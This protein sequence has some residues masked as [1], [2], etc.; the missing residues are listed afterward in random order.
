[1]STI[2]MET[3]LTLAGRLDTVQRLINED[4]ASTLLRDEL[5]ALRDDVVRYET[6]R[7]GLHREMA[8]REAEAHRLSEVVTQTRRRNADVASLYVAAHRLHSTLDRGRVLHALE[9]I[10]ASLLGCEEMA[11]FEIVGDPPLLAPVSTV[12]LRPGSVGTIRLGEGILGRVIET[13]QVWIGDA[14]EHELA[15]RP[16]TACVPLKVDGEVTGAIVL[17]RLLEHKRALE[18]SDLEL[19]DVVSVHAGTA[20]YCTRLRQRQVGKR[21]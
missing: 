4:P 10:V 7:D 2:A 8:V 19:L 12:G 1:M 6:E 13:G 9:E 11:V 3:N 15:G 21:P 17:F 5:R 14:S 18:G 16:V 20:L